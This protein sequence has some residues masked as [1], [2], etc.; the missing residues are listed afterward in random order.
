MMAERSRRALIR[1]PR[2][3]RSRNVRKLRTSEGFSLIE[4]LVALA[5]ISIVGVAIFGGLSTANVST[6]IAE[7]R[8]IGQDLAEAQMEYV[9][10]QC[11]SACDPPQYDPLTSLPANYAVAVN[12]VPLDY[13]GDGDTDDDGIQS[14]TVTVTHN[15]KSV[16]TLNAYKLRRDV[17]TDGCG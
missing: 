10:D 4:I 9:R 17:C 7:E 11:Y 1:S 16:T 5:L 13:E 14:I 12:A 3:T 8:S 6:I 15:G 2:T